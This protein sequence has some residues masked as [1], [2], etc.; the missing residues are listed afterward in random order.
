MTKKT[1]LLILIPLGAAIL[2]GI[3]YLMAVNLRSKAPEH[4]GSAVA[5]RVMPARGLSAD[6]TGTAGNATDDKEL[7]SAD[8]AKEEKALARRAAGL[9]ALDAG[10]YG[11]AL[12]DFAEAR[13]L[14][15]DK[16]YVSELL[17]VTEDLAQ[18]AQV[19]RRSPPP[20][21]AASPRPAPAPS[22]RFASRVH[23]PERTVVKETP[24]QVEAP[25]PVAAPTVAPTSGLLLV[26]TTPHGLLVQIDDVPIDLTPTR[27]SL[28]LGSHHVAFFDGDRKVYETNVDV[29]SGSPTTLLRDLSAELSPAAPPAPA[30]TPFAKERITGEGASSAPGPVAQSSPAASPLRGRKLASAAVQ[31]VPPPLAPQTG[32]LDI[33]SPGLYGEIWIDGRPRGFPPLHAEDLPAGRARVGVRV[34]GVERRSAFVAVRPGLTTS[35]KLS[36]QEVVP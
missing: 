34:N 13:A 9:A 29:K 18:R 20:R 36:R 7:K 6:M 3:G 30:P 4:P 15:G 35:V 23:T 10:D 2:N 14:A 26:T 12:A 27:A 31:A 16:A 33:T 11:R 19:A 5:E 24:M 32:S 22:S 21:P 17:R 8:R 1:K 28:K 25:T